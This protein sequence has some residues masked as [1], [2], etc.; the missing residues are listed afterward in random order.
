MIITRAR[1]HRLSMP[2]I[3]PFT[4]SFGTEYTREALLVELTADT[5]SGPVTG[6]GPGPSAICTICT[7]S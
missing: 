3:A 4:T 7:A 1:L 5:A 2:L 6:W